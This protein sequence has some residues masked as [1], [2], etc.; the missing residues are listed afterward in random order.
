MKKLFVT[1]L[2]LGLL[3]CGMQSEC[4]RGLSSFNVSRFSRR[5]YQPR[6]SFLSKVGKLTMVGGFIYGCYQ[7]NKYRTFR[8]EENEFLQKKIRLKKAKKDI[9]DDSSGFCPVKY[10]NGMLPEYRSDELTEKLK[11]KG[12]TQSEIDW[13]F[14][15][16][17]HRFNG[18]WGFVILNNKRISYDEV[19]VGD[20]PAYYSQNYGEGFYETHNSGEKKISAT[21]QV[22]INRSNGELWKRKVKCDQALS[23][24]FL[25]GMVVIAGYLGTSYFGKKV[26]DRMMYSYF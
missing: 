17:N 10:I 5:S 25:G 26:Y 6:S 24:V 18:R 14:N 20:S 19:V 16:D 22:L 23:R 12:L 8:K 11:G 9:K 15:Q 7:V 1:V 4:S 13:C 21:I 2:S 3:A